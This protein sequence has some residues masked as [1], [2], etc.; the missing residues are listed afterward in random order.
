M[1]GGLEVDVNGEG[2]GEKQQTKKTP[3]VLFKYDFHFFS[4]IKKGGF[5]IFLKAA[6]QNDYLL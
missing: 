2:E 5:Q 6:L 4:C 1:A 3:S